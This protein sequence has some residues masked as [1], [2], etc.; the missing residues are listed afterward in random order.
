MKHTA[1]IRII[2]TCLQAGMTALA[3]L[4]ATSCAP[5]NR[6]P[7]VEFI[8]PYSEGVKA[9]RLDDSQAGQSLTSS[10]T[11]TYRLHETRAGGAVARKAGSSASFKVK[12]GLVRVQ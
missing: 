5:A 7:T 1:N 4:L 9:S 12:G 8:T 2:D 3:V 6:D 10:A 11:S